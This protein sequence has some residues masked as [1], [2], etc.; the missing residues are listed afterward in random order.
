MQKVPTPEFIGINGSGRQSLVDQ[1]TNAVRALDDFISVLRRSAPHQ[2]D[3]EDRA[4]Y[5]AA[6]EAHT[7]RMKEVFTLRQNLMDEAGQIVDARGWDDGA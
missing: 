5:V 7:E 2:R 1:K 6:A 4:S 3:Y